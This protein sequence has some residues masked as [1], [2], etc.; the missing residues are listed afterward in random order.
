CPPPA[1]ARAQI[2]STL[3]VLGVGA[4]QI[5][6]SVCTDINAAGEYDE[7][8]LVVTHDSLYVFDPRDPSRATHALGIAEIEEFRTMPAVGS[9]LLQARIEDVWLDVIR[10][11]NRLKYTFD[12]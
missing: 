9:G 2:E 10:F 1:R 5:L 12:R 3:Q 4:D 11:S 8:W 7:Q 6:L